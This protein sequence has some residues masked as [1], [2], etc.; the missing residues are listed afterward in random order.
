MA[1]NDRKWLRN[2]SPATQEIV[3]IK[4]LIAKLREDLKSAEMA[5]EFIE[6]NYTALTEI[7]G[8]E[9]GEEKLCPAE[10]LSLRMDALA[11]LRATQI[12]LVSMGKDLV[13]SVASLWIIDDEEG[14]NDHIAEVVAFNAAIARAEKEAS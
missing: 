3:R 6:Q 5:K 2:E 7:I 8:R 9:D 13:K 1:D 12:T 11:K 10:I 14:C 4:D